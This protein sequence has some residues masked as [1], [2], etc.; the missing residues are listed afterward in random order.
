[1]AAELFPTSH[2]SL[3]MSLANGATKLVMVG[4]PRATL[5]AMT[6]PGGVAVPFIGMAAASAVAAL[7]VCIYDRETMGRSLHDVVN[8]RYT[9]EYAVLGSARSTARSDAESGA[10]ATGTV[11]SGTRSGDGTSGGGGGVAQSEQTPLL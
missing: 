6:T 1:M 7:A 8:N 3:G 2:R 5:W 11:R 4:V 10:A 9:D